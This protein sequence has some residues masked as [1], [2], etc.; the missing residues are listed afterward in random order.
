MELIRNRGFAA[1]GLFWSSAVTSTRPVQ[2]E[3]QEVLPRLRPGSQLVIADGEWQNVELTI[4]ANGSW[5]R[6][7]LVRPETPHGVHFTG[8][9]QL[10][11]VGSNLIVAD[12]V[13][14]NGRYASA[15][16]VVGL[17]NSRERCDSCVALE[18]DMQDLNAGSSRLHYLGVRGKDVTVAYSR[19]GGA[20]SPGH[21]VYDSNPTEADRPARLHLLNNLFYDRGALSDE[22]GYELLQMGES[23]VQAQSMFGRIEG[24]V[25]R[26]AMVPH[27]DTELVTIKS[28]DWLIRGN[29]FQNTLGDLTLRSANR[30]LVQQ[31]S[32]LGGGSLSASGVRVHGAGHAVV[33]NFFYKNANPAPAQTARG[34]AYYYSVV[35]PA[36]TVEE[37]SDGEA[38]IPVAK[39]VVV[40]DN[41][42]YDGLYNVH[43]G[44]FFPSY[45]IMP[46]GITVTNNLIRTEQHSPIFVLPRGSE[47]TFLCQNDIDGNVLQGT[48]GLQGFLADSR[49][50]TIHPTL[51]E[52]LPPPAF[53][54]SAP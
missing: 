30:V 1:S 27:A 21:Y 38:G 15:A 34:E 50:P 5:D 49:N 26:D 53:V 39:N 42:F 31:N 19:F 32:F 37:V 45:P 44:S 51:S 11:F 17:G 25:F 18:L 24:N 46:R 20:R 9:T 22:N 33:G 47:P 48:S 54:P 16:T 29:T 43:L 3:L 7:I 10:R 6:P 35:I 23:R 2:L 28:S 36:G 41:V 52:S 8:R 13:L 4:R 14:R 12:L 40:A